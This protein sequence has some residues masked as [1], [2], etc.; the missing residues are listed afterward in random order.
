M[1][2]RTLGPVL[3]LMW[4]LVWH[5]R[6]SLMSCASRRSLFVFVRCRTRNFRS[7]SAAC[8]LI[9]CFRQRTSPLMKRLFLKSSVKTA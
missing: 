7:S 6:R 2:H 4:V 5:S 8:G 1:S 9:L 3:S